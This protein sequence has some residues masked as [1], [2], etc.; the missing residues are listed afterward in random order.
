MRSTS[1][2]R[3][4]VVLLESPHAVETLG[5]PDPFG[6]PAPPDLSPISMG[7]VDFWQ[8]PTAYAVAERATTET[9]LSGDHEAI[10]GVKSAVNRLAAHCDLIVGNCGYMYVAGT[11]INPEKPT[12]LSAL[13]FLR[14]ALESTEAPVGIITFDRSGTERLLR[15]HPQR[16]RLRILG[17]N[18]MPGWASVAEPGGLSEKRLDVDRLRTEILELCLREKQPTGIFKDIGSA[19]L[20]CTLTPVF[21]P[22]IAAALAAP[23]WDLATTAH[24]LIGQ[25]KSLR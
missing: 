16:D 17:L 6:V 3:L 11:Q 21:R 10:A 4:G 7:H 8:V 15:D 19:I 1:D 18:T 12:I 14:I 9:L 23:I 5:F 13:Q 2:R 20:Q 22:I 24:A 25:Q